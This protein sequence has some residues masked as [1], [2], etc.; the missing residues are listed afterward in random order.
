MA[1]PESPLLPL[2]RQFLNSRYAEEYIPGPDVSL[3]PFSLPV[4]EEFSIIT[5]EVPSIQ[6]QKWPQSELP[7]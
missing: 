6:T 7:V 4:I 3:H 2:I 1:E 5:R